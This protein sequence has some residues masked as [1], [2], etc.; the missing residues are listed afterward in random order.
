VRQ[1][2]KFIQTLNNIRKVC[3]LLNMV[4]GG[5]NHEWA[6]EVWS[7][8]GVRRPEATQTFHR[9]MLWRSGPV[10]FPT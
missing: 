4:M 6:G 2:Q 10:G 9:S 7:A 5:L 8:G 1:Y 3:I